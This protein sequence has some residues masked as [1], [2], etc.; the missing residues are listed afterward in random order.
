MMRCDS[1]MWKRTC[2]GGF[3][4]MLF[5]VALPAEEAVQMEFRGLT[6]NATLTDGGEPG[7]PV[8][9]LL[10]GTLAHNDMEIMQALREA[11]LE[12][13]FNSLAITL[14]LGLDDRRGMLDCAAVHRHLH[15]DAIDELEAW[16]HWLTARGMERQVL[17][18]HSRGGNQVAWYMAERQPESAV[19][20]VLVAPQLWTADKA[21][22]GYEGRFGDSL[23][24]RIDAARKLDSDAL[25]QD[26]GFVYCDGAT[27]TAES[28]LSYHAPDERMHTPNLAGRI[29]TPVLVIAGSDDTSVPGVA[30]AMAGVDGVAVVEIEGADHFFR[31]LYVYDLVEAIADFLD[32]NGL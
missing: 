12:E 18:G 3:L 31:D 4:A 29:R 21:E 32:N 16:Q 19:A 2:V 26:V 25:L 5:S 6:L 27:V 30:A 23:S 13:G 24:A 22:A 10:H 14:S 17:L 11:L 8:F 20:T 9:L 15:T 28:F 1:S 7:K